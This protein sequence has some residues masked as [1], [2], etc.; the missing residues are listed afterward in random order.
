MTA[1]N[2]SGSYKDSAQSS[3]STPTRRHRPRTP[4]TPRNTHLTTVRCRTPGDRFIPNRSASDLEFSRFK[5]TPSKH[6]SNSE[7]V[8]NSP[9]SNVNANTPNSILE[10]RRRCAMRE[11]LL[12]L[13][14]HSTDNRVLSFNQTPSSNHCKEST[15]GRCKLL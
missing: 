12:A 3:I 2:P 9:P 7:S 10:V 1:I 6:S 5:M 4:F 14:G 11:R 13:K 8:E 15:P